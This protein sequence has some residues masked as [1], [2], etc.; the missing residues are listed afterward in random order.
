M[1]WRHSLSPLS[2]SFPTDKIPAVKRRWFSFHFLMIVRHSTTT[3]RPGNW[4]ISPITITITG[5]SAR[6]S[7]EL[8][9]PLSGTLMKQPERLWWP[10]VVPR[11]HH[12]IS[13]LSHTIP[14]PLPFSH[15]RTPNVIRENRKY[16]SD[17]RWWWI[18]SLPLSYLS[19]I[20]SDFI[21]SIFFRPFAFSRYCYLPH[22]FLSLSNRVFLDCISNRNEAP[23]S[24]MFSRHISTTINAFSF[25]PPFPFRDVLSAHS[26]GFSSLEKSIRLLWACDSVRHMNR[27]S[28]RHLGIE[29]FAPRWKV[30]PFICSPFQRELSTFNQLLKCK[31]PRATSTHNAISL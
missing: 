27:W 2:L 1:L 3:N 18:R 15:T 28:K 22:H 30:Q 10:T 12:G 19:P 26:T 9:L 16:L 5:S 25:P 6:C 8:T 7:T 20:T 29:L 31:D 4:I 21:T 13:A 17:G 11:S 23:T 14:T 24:D